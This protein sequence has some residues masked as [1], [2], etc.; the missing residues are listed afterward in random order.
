LLAAA[1]SVIVGFYAGI[2]ISAIGE[3]SDAASLVARGAALIL[4]LVGVAIFVNWRWLLVLVTYVFGFHS[5]YT[6]FDSLGN[7]IGAMIHGVAAILTIPS[8]WLAGSE[9]PI[10]SPI[11]S[12]GFQTHPELL[13]YYDL[14]VLFVSVAAILRHR[15]KSSNNAEQG[16]D[17]KPLKADQPPHK[18]SPNT[19]P[20]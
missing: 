3:G 20:P 19:Q 4:P 6:A 9:L 16:A 15:R 7:S 8:A 18:L 1:S 14:A 13:W 2:Y 10:H 11:T 5:G 12:S 17:G